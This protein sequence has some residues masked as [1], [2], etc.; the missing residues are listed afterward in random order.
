MPFTLSHGCLNLVEEVT[1]LHATM[2]WTLVIDMTVVLF[3]H[4]G[5]V[6]GNCKD[7]LAGPCCCCG[8]KLYLQELNNA[9]HLHV[10]CCTR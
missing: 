9:G 8:P 1:V 2:P 10:L 3:G 7:K 6:L 4:M 5:L